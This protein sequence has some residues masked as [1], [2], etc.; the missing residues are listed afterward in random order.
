MPTSR[1]SRSRPKVSPYRLE[2]RRSLA[3]MLGVTENQVN[4]KATTTEHLGFI[5]R[6]EGLAAQAVVLLET[7]PEPS[8]DPRRTGAAR[9]SRRRPPGVRPLGTGV[10]R[11]RPE[12]FEVD[13]ILGFEA[14]GEGPHALLSVRKRGANTEWVARELART[15]GVKP[16]EVGFAGLK[17]RNA[18]TT[19]HFTVPRGKRAAEE[20]VG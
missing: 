16:F 5:G 19:Q 8:D 6:N 11:A 9:R 17:D 10:L 14:S 13:E 3:Q 18:I 2:I 15:V 1:C 12:D 4:I 20:F 7:M